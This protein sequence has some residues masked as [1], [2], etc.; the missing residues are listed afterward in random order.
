MKADEAIEILEEHNKWQLGEPS[1]E[2][3]I[4]QP[5]PV[6]PV[7]AAIEHAIAHMKRSIDC[8]LPEGYDVYCIGRDRTNGYWIEI[9]DIKNNKLAREIGM[10]IIYADSLDEL[11]KEAREMILDSEWYNEG[12]YTVHVPA[13]I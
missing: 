3:E 5:I 7:G 9:R 8:S 12:C 2:V 6:N 1:Y 10:K 4:P 13:R 11:F